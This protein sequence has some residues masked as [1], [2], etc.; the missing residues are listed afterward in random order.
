MQHQHNDDCKSA[1]YDGRILPA[2]IPSSRSPVPP[3][4]LLALAIAAGALIAGNRAAQAQVRVDGPPEAVHVE[5]SDV[6]LREVLDALQ[7]K[8]SLHYRSNDALDSRV[9]GTFDGPLRRV[10]AR[11]LDGYD[12]AMK[13]TPQDI[14]VLVLRQGQLDAKT[15]A[16]AMP[17]RDAPE[18]SP[19]PV[20]TAAQANRYERGI[21]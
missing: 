2:P 19:A 11:I 21:R 4:W 18:R 17:V 12:F 16:A 8:F 13:I 10:A 3:C 14:D 15:V 20:M 5:A 6:S 1:G 7:A 9:T